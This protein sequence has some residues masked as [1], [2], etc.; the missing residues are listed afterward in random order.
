M[1]AFVEMDFSG[2]DGTETVSNSYKPRLRHAYGQVGN[3][4]VG[5]TWSTFMDA[6]WI[7][8]PTT[9]DFAGAAGATFVRQAMFRW[10]LDE[11]FDVAIE[12]PESK[13]RGTDSSDELP[14][15]IAR[16]YQGGDIAW[17]VAGVLQHFSADDGPADGES[18]YNLGF[19]G[20]VNFKLGDGNNSISLQTNLNSNRYTYYGFSNPSAVVDG[21][22]IELIDHTSFVVAYNHDWGHAKSTFAYGVVSFDDDF[23]ADDDI[24]TISTIH[25]NYRWQ[26]YEQVDY[27]A[28]VSRAMQELVNG[29]DGDNLR[30]QFSVKYSF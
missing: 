26:P 9:V 24:D 8:F 14:D 7:Y 11:G 19:S 4:L 30:L 18:E 29:N 23:L 25:A 12:N 17:Q 27:L 10:T 21:D 16:Y 1:L 2:G 5:Q 28:E 22:Q 15:F 13:V 3:L 20:G 6:Q